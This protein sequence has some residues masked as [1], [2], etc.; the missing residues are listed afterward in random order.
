MEYIKIL[1][2]LAFESN[3]ITDDAVLRTHH[4][5]LTQRARSELSRIKKFKPTD[6]N[7]LTVFER[8]ALPPTRGLMSELSTTK[9]RYGDHHLNAAHIGFMQCYSWLSPQI[10]SLHAKTELLTNSPN[11]ISN[12]KTTESFSKPALNR[13]T[14]EHSDHEDDDAKLNVED[15]VLKFAKSLMSNGDQAGLNGVVYTM[16]NGELVKTDEQSMV[17]KVSLFDVVKG[18]IERID[19]SCDC[20]ECTKNK[21]DP[22]MVEVKFN[23][24]THCVV[25]RDVHDAMNEFLK[26]VG[27][28]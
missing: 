23:P 10:E 2:A 16:I 24:K 5:A 9:N 13:E 21:R 28:R 4:N 1:Q 17:G 7:P 20:E 15:E 3:V 22:E 14:T 12:D 18:I 11:V 8:W 27:A 25:P 19:E 6:E 26:K